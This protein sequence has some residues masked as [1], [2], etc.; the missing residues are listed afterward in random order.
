M[1]VGII[2]YGA[3]GA[4]LRQVLAEAGAA[5]VSVL[6]RPASEDK[7]RA[8]V[9]PN[10]AVT[11]DF[12]AFAATRPN[13]VAECAGH[14][15]LRSHGARTLEAGFDLVIASVGALADRPTEAML[16]AAAAQGGR[17]IVPAGALGGLDALGAARAA[18]LK[19]VRYT[20]RKAPKAWRGTKAEGMIDL[21]QVGEPAAFFS[22]TAREA[23]LSFPQNANVVAAAAL[24]GLGFD[25]TQVVL[26]ADPHTPGNRHLL[27]ADG[28]FGEIS[29]S[30]LART[31]PQNPKTS[32]LAPYS[33]ARAILNLHERVVV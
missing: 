32:M 28:P 16:R 20:S 2:G 24:A 29:V 11:T 1:R 3:I 30:V 4:T 8:A 25:A 10:I 21:D 14:D 13:V 17:M 9:E 19:R 26:M 15:G 27:E 6:V 18:G 22:G 23:A 31:L 5:V 12:E 33:L 7:A